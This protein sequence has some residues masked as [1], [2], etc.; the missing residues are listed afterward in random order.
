[1]LLLNLHA[2]LNFWLYSGVVKFF[3]CWPVY[4]GLVNSRLSLMCQEIFFYCLVLHY[5]LFAKTLKTSFDG[6]HQQLG[7]VRLDC[8]RL[9]WVR[10]VS[11]RDCLVLITLSIVSVNFSMNKEQNHKST[12]MYFFLFWNSDLNSTLTWGCW[13]WIWRHKLSNCNYLR[14]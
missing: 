14:I 5:Q 2:V 10:I 13:C 4:S 7:W 8:C 6:S 12:I 11:Y 3:C 9:L 1:M